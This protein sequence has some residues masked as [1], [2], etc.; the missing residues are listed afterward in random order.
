MKTIKTHFKDTWTEVSTGNIQDILYS[1]E[2]IHVYDEETAAEQLKALHRSVG[3]HTEYGV[4]HTRELVSTEDIDTRTVN[5]SKEEMFDFIL[6][7]TLT[8]Q[9]DGSLYSKTD[10][11]QVSK[12]YNVTINDTVMSGYD[13]VDAINEYVSMQRLK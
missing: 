11:T 9:P 5:L 1:T 13:L 2:T 4:K 7:N 12:K 3:E 6:N 8:I 10:G